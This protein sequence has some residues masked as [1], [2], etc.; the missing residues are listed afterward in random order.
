M[1]WFKKQ[2]LIVKRKNKVQEGTKEGEKK[3]REKRHFPCVSILAPIAEESV[4]V[5]F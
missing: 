5:S 4:F 1:L 2:L 3:K